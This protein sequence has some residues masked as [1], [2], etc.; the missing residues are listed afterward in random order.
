[1]FRMAFGALML[2]SGIRFWS[3]GWIQ[4]FYV[5]P[6]FFFKY[7][8]FEWVQPLPEIGLYL[9]FTLMLL[10]S[11]GILLGYRY[12]IATLLFFLSFNYFELLDKTYYLN[13][14]YLI[15]LL[16]IWLMI[17]PTHK[18]LSLDAKAG[19]VANT[20]VPRLYIYLLQFQIAAVYFFAGM[21]KVAPDWLFHAMPMKI[22][23]RQFDPNSFLGLV[24]HAP[25]VAF[26]A[27]WFGCIYDLSLPFLLSFKK[28]R[29]LAYVAVIVFH[30]AT[31]VLFPIGVFPFVM[32][33]LTLI[34]FPAETWLK[35]ADKYLPRVKSWLNISAVK[36]TFSPR[37]I[38]IIIPLISWQILF[39][40]RSWIYPGN[41][42]WHEQGFNF[43]W[44]VMRVEKAG[45]A[46]FYVEDKETGKEWEVLNEE[47]LTPVQEKMMAVQ[48][49]FIL[50]YAKFL[51]EEYKWRH[52]IKNPVVTADVFVTMNGSPLRRFIKSDVNLHSLKDGWSHKT[53]ILPQE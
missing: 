4:E 12:R 41:V 20:D 46:T 47:Y 17:I 53:W 31:W 44:R 6:T 10:S 18:T 7:Y 8:G 40:L 9:V 38:W 50:Q 37:L 26:I 24:M 29:P 34:F 45:I 27:S 11:L 22:W 3:K 42:Y 23:L 49:D 33:G 14:Y 25:I 15:S 5:E 28:T 30:L 35:A 43:S 39:P 16:S 32:I 19:R 21:A 51:A 36:N 1:M 2:F 52:D 48:P 13:H